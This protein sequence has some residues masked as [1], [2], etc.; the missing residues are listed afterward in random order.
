MSRAIVIGGG[1]SGLTAA[2]WAREAGLE[3]YLLEAT[4]SLGG[5]NQTVKLAD[6][7]VDLGEE[8]FDAYPS[9]L[10]DLC[11]QVGLAPQPLPRLQRIVRL[12]G[13]DWVLPEGLNL[14]TG[15]GLHRLAALPFARKVKWRLTTERF[16][17][18]AMVKDELLD[19]FFRRRLGPEIWEV[20]EPYLR[21]M[22]GG[23]LEEVVAS[24]ALTALLE[25]ERQ[26]GLMAASRRLKAE[27]GG[28]LAGGM[29]SLSQA[30]SAYLLDKAQVLTGQEALA[31]TRDKGRWQVHTPG[32]RL[33]AEAVVFALPAPRAAR[34]FRPSAPQMTA[35][36]NQFPYHHSAKVFLLYR[37]PK[38]EAG[39]VEYYW[40]RAEGY[41]GTALRLGQLEPTLTL[42]RVQFAGDMA[43]ST[44]AEL[45][46]L[47]QQDLSRYLQTQVRPLAAWVFRQPLSRPQFTQGHTRRR[48]ALEQALVHAPGLFLTGSYLAGPGLARQVAHSHKTTQQMLNFLVL[49]A[50]PTN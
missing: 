20:L 2:Y 3:V 14:A 38:T 25:L 9:A 5:R 21:A 15:Y 28:C 40:A 39:P 12:R 16:V 34:V 6:W 42:A 27:G 23:P 50:L 26:G 48:E 17:P 36:L 1:L 29:G 45:S 31:I 37:H 19:A 35:L 32:G 4:R 22:L 41:S 8:Y 10:F 43:R 33:E 11:T 7:A 30:L 18:P 46:R 49:S 44:D 13:Q 24:E 47:A